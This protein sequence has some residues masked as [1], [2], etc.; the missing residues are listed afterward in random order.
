[1]CD[2]VCGEAVIMRAGEGV[3]HGRKCLPPQALGSEATKP[4]EQPESNCVCVREDTSQSD[5]Q[6]RRKFPH[7]AAPSS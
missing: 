5:G 7:L 2:H 1:M 4:E 3:A 6:E